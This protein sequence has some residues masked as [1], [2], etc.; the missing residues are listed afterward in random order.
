MANNFEISCAW[1]R[2]TNPFFDPHKNHDG[3]GY[4]QYSG[5]I[6]ATL[7]NG[8]EL[9]LEVCDTSC[10]WFGSRKTATVTDGRR[11]FPL[12]WG[13]MDGGA[14]QPTCKELAHLCK[15]AR[16][17]FGMARKLLSEAFNAA[18]MVAWAEWRRAHPIED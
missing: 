3:G 15:S 6:V 4:W 18:N 9:V 7:A 14:P 8:Q 10:G 5:G 1:G 12:Y 13:S 17:S 16:L 11:S 2:C